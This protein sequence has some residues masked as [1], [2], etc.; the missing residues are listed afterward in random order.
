M[1]II[2]RICDNPDCNKRSY[3]SIHPAIKFCPY[4][5]KKMTDLEE[6]LEREQKQLTGAKS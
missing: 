6:I 5:G 1:E 4:C 3:G 2:R